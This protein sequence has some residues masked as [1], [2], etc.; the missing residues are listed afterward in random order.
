M[1][2]LISI[3]NGIGIGIGAVIGVAVLRTLFHVG[4]C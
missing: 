3:C 1:T 4:L 2:F